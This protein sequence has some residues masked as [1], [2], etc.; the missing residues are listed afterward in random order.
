MDIDTD[1]STTVASGATTYNRPP[2]YNYNDPNH[3]PP[4]ANTDYIEI[5]ANYTPEILAI[6][7]G[8]DGCNLK[9]ITE[10]NNIAF[11]WHNV[12]QKKFEIW[13][14]RIKFNKVITQINNHIQ[15]ALRVKNY[16]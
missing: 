4:F 15:Y 13:G 12:E 1:N 8:K 6:A 9:K 7:I 3:K 2:L 11:I 16:G 10:S 14:K 5:P